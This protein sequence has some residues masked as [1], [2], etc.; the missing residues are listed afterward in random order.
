M[1]Q[2][3]WAR[4]LILAFVL[5]APQLRAQEATPFSLQQAM[6]YA[7]QHN[8]A[9][10]NSRADIEISKS[11]IL[12]T[13][14]IGLPQI[15]G[16]VGFQNFINIPTQ[17]IPASAFNPAA[18]SDELMPVQF[19][20]KWNAT[21]GIQASQLIFDGA[22]IV[23]LQASKTFA[24]LSKNQLG[25][26]ENDVKADVSQAY[27]TVLVAGENIKILM[28]SLANSQKLLNE[29]REIYK[30]GFIEESDVDQLTLLVLNIKNSISRSERQ[31]NLSYKLL[32]LQM[33]MDINENITVSETLQDIIGKINI[34][35]LYNQEFQL[36]GH[37]EYKL[38]QTNKNLMQL[39]LRRER[40]AYLPSVGAFFSHQESA[41]RN[42]FNFFEGIR[43]WYPG[44]I[45]GI[46]M[47]IPIFDSGMKYAR[48]KQAKLE[49]EKAT[50][51]AEF[52]E[53]SLKLQ[54]QNSKADL[55]D[56]FD[57]LNVEKQ[58][59]VLAEKI[60]NKTMVKY[61]EGLSTSLD[62]NQ[63][64][65]QYLNTQGNYINTLF[66]LLSAKTRFDKAMS[67]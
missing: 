45:W 31:L 22:Y 20:T 12:E 6:D 63:V 15:S 53:Q 32:K 14:S 39:N 29:T 21:A 51:S 46:N 58:N 42:Q 8:Y 44:T 52:A 24:Q 10:I 43:P 57:R 56:A 19:G 26:T 66:E 1:N 3:K 49:Y 7:K 54:A 65:N 36:S 34:E 13:T 9:M 27:Y 33:G 25:K 35:S 67:F 64:Q 50:T 23:G 17:V 61:Q 38:A 41:F 28:Q 4:I 59:L 48:T 11:K 60:Q 55:V 30:S 5:S 37:V 47:T 16:E 40:V 2:N 18:D 62:L